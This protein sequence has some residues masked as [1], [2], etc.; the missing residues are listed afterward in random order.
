M[1]RKHNA[2]IVGFCHA[3]NARYILREESSHILTLFLVYS[4]VIVFPCSVQLSYYFE[5]AKKLFDIED[6]NSGWWFQGRG[7]GKEVDCFI[8]GTLVY[9]Y[10][11]SDW[12]IKD[13]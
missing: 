7:A 8:Q 11:Y 10:M 5:L 3:D 9:V 13:V 12:Q 2:P 6:T 4:T 1:K